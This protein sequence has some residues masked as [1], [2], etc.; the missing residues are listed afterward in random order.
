MP[1]VFGSNGL[2]VHWLGL[3]LLILLLLDAA[4]LPEEVSNHLR[5]HPGVLRP[6]ERWS[7]A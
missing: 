4:L 7:K 5:D 3:K 2:S 6:A 1:S